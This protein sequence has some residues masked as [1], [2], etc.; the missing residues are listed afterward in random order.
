LAKRFRSTIVE[1]G[2]KMGIGRGRLSHRTGK[3]EAVIDIYIEGRRLKGLVCP[4]IACSVVSVQH[5][6]LI[7]LSVRRSAEFPEKA[8]EGFALLSV[9]Q[10]AE[11]PTPTLVGVA[12]IDGFDILVGRDILNS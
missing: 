6:D 7:S 9:D 4:T 3:E 5:I 1:D 12:E 8:I 11:N 10:N 2:G